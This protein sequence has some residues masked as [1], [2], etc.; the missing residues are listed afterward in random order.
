MR[1]RGK[2]NNPS[3]DIIRK[4]RNISDESKD[5]EELLDQIIPII[6]ELFY[7]LTALHAVTS[8]R[9]QKQNNITWA[10]SSQEIAGSSGSRRFLFKK[11]LRLL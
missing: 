5:A 3:Q 9:F 10:M 11:T 1:E 4:I 8:G 7:S 2:D 6:A